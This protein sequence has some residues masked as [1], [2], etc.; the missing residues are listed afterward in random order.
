MFDHGNANSLLKTRAQE[1]ALKAKN[2]IMNLCCPHC[3]IAYADFTGC[4]AL[5]CQ[6]CKGYF[7]GYC[8]P[9]STTGRGTHEF[10]RQCLMNETNNGSYYATDEEVERA[11]RRYKTREIKKFLQ[12]QGK[13]ELQNAIVIELAKDLHDVGIQPDALFELGN[14]HDDIVNENEC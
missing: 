11:Q 4:M 12:K 2:T 6:T 5:Q 1:Q 7:C 3:K 14:L 9:A 13:K 10:V 8:H